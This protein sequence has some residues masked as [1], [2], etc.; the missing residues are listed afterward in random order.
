MCKRFP[1]VSD[2]Q[3]SPDRLLGYDIQLRVSNWQRYK[4]TQG[5]ERQETGPLEKHTLTQPSPYSFCFLLR[6]PGPKRSPSDQQRQLVRA[7]PPCYVPCTRAL[8]LSWYAGSS[9]LAWCSPPIPWQ[10]QQ[11]DT[12][13]TT[14]PQVRIYDTQ[15]F[16]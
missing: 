15:C 4:S 2:N 11:P 3:P 8:G 16:H 9:S 14:P 7:N 12:F 5:L 6:G 13:Q 1:L 10:G